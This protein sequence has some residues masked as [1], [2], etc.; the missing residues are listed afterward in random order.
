MWRIANYELWCIA[1]VLWRTIVSSEL[2]CNACES[3]VESGRH[4][5]VRRL[6]Q[7]RA[8]GEGVHRAHGRG[9]L[10]LPERSLQQRQEKL[11]FLRMLR[12]RTRLGELREGR[13]EAVANVR[14]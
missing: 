9:Q 4:A 3:R 12:V 8:L 5:R 14:E 10:L 7:R 13:V 6:R 11:A 1:S 2:W